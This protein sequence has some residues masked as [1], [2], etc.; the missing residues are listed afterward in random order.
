MLSLYGVFQEEEW[1]GVT[2]PL[3]M[4]SEQTPHLTM[5][6]IKVKGRVSPAQPRME[7]VVEVGGWGA[8]GEEREFGSAET[9]WPEGVW[10][11]YHLFQGHGW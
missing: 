2:G 9:M 4:P 3:A 5:E 1:E 8:P 6:R 7:G 10:P 11:P